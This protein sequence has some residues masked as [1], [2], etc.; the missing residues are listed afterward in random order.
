MTSFKR[1][2]R[3]QWLIVAHDL[4]V[5]AAALTATL[6]LRFEDARLVERLE[7]LPQLLL[8]FVLFAAVVYFLFGLHEPKWR[9]A[10]LPELLRI[11]QASA[12]LA[13]SLLVLDY[14]LVTP[15]LYGTFF[16]GKITIVLYFVIQTAFLGG[17]RIAYRYFR[18]ARKQRRLRSACA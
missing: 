3:R 5:T 6:C 7:W 18:Y 12:V 13:V 1:L 2:T 15:N 17:T 11:I 9:F 4:L 10:S 8:G 16:F 14:I